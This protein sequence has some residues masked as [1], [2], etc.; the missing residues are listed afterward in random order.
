MILINLA[1]RQEALE[2]I[3]RLAHEWEWTLFDLNLV[4][5]TLPTHLHPAGALVDSLPDDPLVQR[6]QALQCPVVR[7]GER[8]HPNDLQV[9]AILPDLPRAAVL[10]VEHFADRGFKTITF[11]ARDPWSGGEVLFDA[12]QERAQEL[13][14]PPHLL[15]FKSREQDKILKYQHRERDI[16]R[17]LERIP[18][19]VGVFCYGDRT[20]AQICTLCAVHGIAVPEQVAILGSGNDPTICSV[21]PAPLSSVDLNFGERARLAMLLLRDLIEGKL[22]P[23][24]APTLVQPLGIATRHSTDVLAVSEIRVAHAI[25]FMWDHLQQDISV[26]DV[27]DAA[28]VDRRWLERAFRRELGRSVNVELRRKRLEQLKVLL[29]TTDDPVADLTPR[30]GFRSPQY[31]TRAFHKA[32]GITPGHFRKKNRATL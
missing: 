5:R 20:A 23:G 30:I 8:K 26:T 18:K 2:E 28:G 9:P 14:I 21:T 19:P 11:A 7:F 15:Q 6:L 3:V 12:F 24:I 1:T 25:R 27:A 29:L 16:I 13:G 17:G 32:F 4:S 31:L 10:A 22:Q